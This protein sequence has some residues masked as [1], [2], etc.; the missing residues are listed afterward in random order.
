VKFRTISR[1]VFVNRIAAFHGIE[2]LQTFAV[3]ARS[4]GSEGFAGKTFDLQLGFLRRPVATE[5]MLVRFELFSADG[6]DAGV[7]GVVIF[8]S[9][10]L[11]TLTLPLVSTAGL[12]SK[13][14]VQ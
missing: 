4:D 13:K 12:S 5:D 14:T 11:E 7:D 2:L 8:D 9:V 6:G 10:E 3:S 1:N